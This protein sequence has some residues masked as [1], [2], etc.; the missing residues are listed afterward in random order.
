MT[1]RATRSAPKASAGEKASRTGSRLAQGATATDEAAMAA[2]T[3]ST[4]AESLDTTT[5]APAENAGVAES[6][7]DAPGFDASLF[8]TLGASPVGFA[9]TATRI[10]AE[11]RDQIL[12]G[13]VKAGDRLPPERDLSR[14]FDTNRNTLREAIREL[15]ALNLVTVRRGDGVRVNDFIQTGDLRLLPHF[16]RVAAGTGQ[17]ERLIDD[18]LRFRRL[19]V[20]EA[21]ALAAENAGARDVAT[22]QAALDRVAAAM[23]NGD[24]VAAVIEHDFNFF[25]ALLDS[26]NSVVARWAFNTF[27]GIFI[28]VL[29]VLPILWVVTDDYLPSLTALVKAIGAHDTVGA[30]EAAFRHFGE[31]DQMILSRLGGL[32]P[33]PMST[34]DTT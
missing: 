33:Q 8:A 17:F 6:V 25:R 23:E 10:L 27:V 20:A 29:R 5:R 19:M 1:V 15:S 16:L 14:Q 22:L 24:D 2:A 11:L 32:K 31:S 3:M 30:R 28:H 26:S 34:G 18:T 21:A 4:T 7:F 12:V 13:A 9:T